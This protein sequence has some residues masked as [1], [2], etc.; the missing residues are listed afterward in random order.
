MTVLK[1][2]A[3]EFKKMGDP[4][5]QDEHI[6]YVCYVQTKSI[7][8]EIDNWMR[9]NPRD[10]KLTTNVG[11]AIKESL[12]NND[13]FHE[14]NRGILLSAEKVQWNNA[15][16]ELEIEFENPDI[17]GNIDGGH[18]LRAIIDA[19]NHNSLSDRRYVFMEIIV[20]LDSPVELAAAR[21]IS[22]QVDQKSISELEN[23]FDCLKKPFK[24]LNFHNRIQYKMF[25]HDNEK[26]T[27]IDV[28]E[29]IA[30]LLMFSQEIYPYKDANN[31]L[32]EVQPIQCYSGKEAS[33]KKFL[34]CNSN[35]ESQQKA[36][37]EDMVRKMEPIIGDIFELWET[38]ETTFATISNESGK[39]YGTR[40]YSKF[41]NGNIVGKSFFEE[42]EVKYIVPKGIMY[43]MVASFRA[44]IE[45]DKETGEYRWKKNP[46]DTWYKMGSKLVTILLDE[47]AENPD[48]LA[49]N[50]NLWSN[51]F[52]EVYIYAYL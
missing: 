6:K 35:A 41:D 5:G 51:L 1:M 14:L 49:K 18:T 16:E 7:P 42:Q 45:T 11:K 38:I 52:K 12:D 9:T 21:N 4:N 3:K 25:E 48:S 19:Q 50:S 39:R 24:S 26:V 27:P 33:L 46:I 15:T 10:Q 44:L 37:R 36:N 8:K 40:K 17:H 30:I 20:G 47:K 28:R 23:S 2:R 29:M 32:S 34:K 31:S 13:N 22:F 43:P